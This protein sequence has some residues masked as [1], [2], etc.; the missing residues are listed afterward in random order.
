M[1]MREFFHATKVVSGAG[2]V[3]TVGQETAA[4]GGK[5]VLI[6]TDGFLAKSPIMEKVTKSL[7]ES[8]I[9]YIVYDKV[10]P[11]PRTTDC[12]ATADMA[13]AEGVDVIIGLGGGSSMDQAKATAALVTNGGKCVDWD[14]VDLKEYMLPVICI[15]TTSGTGSEVT[16]V[17]VITDEERK[18]KM[19]VFDPIKLR[20]SVAIADPELLTSLPP[21]LTASTGIDAL[22]HAIEAY[23]CKV[24]QPITDA[25]ALYAI[26]IISK[27]I[28]QA[29]EDGS[30]LEVRHNMLMGSLIAGMAFINSNVGAVHAIS[31]TVGGWYDTPHGVGNSIFLPYIM[32]YNIPANPEKF[33]T[34]ARYLGVDP[35]GKTTEELALAGVEKVKEL[36]AKVKIP[37]LIEL[38]YIKEENFRAIAERSAENA[39]S[40]D[41]AR[42]IDADGY[43]S[44][45]LKAYRGN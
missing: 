45:I 6:I 43:M 20:P 44:V 26:D 9:E 29:V 16:F 18:Y 32:E 8:D 5:K 10:R 15:P 3:K 30:N 35:E 41:N 27:N 24:S 37:K 11:N 21:S 39:L 2:V 28:V 22:T 17:A 13:K 7:K 19:S 36:N 33:A 25:L 1:D 12:D 14:F 38:D 31:E 23:T 34:V 40:Q 4:L 42:D